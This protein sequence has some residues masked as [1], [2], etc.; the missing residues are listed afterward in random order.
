MLKYIFFFQYPI[1]AENEFREVETLLFLYFLQILSLELQ[2]VLEILM[3]RS[4]C[5]VI[6]TYLDHKIYTELYKYR[7]YGQ[8]H[9]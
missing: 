7:G 3:L 9:N 6:F 8:W 5:I 1:E 2:L 4:N